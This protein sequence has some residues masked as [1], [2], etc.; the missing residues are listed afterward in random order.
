[1]KWISVAYTKRYCP[2]FATKNI[3][4][5]RRWV[6]DLTTFSRC[7]IENITEDYLVSINILRVST[8][9]EKV[10]RQKH[11]PCRRYHTLVPRL[12]SFNL[13]TSRTMLRLRRKMKI[14]LVWSVWSSQFFNAPYAATRKAWTIQAWRVIRTLTSAMPVLSSARY[15][16]RPTEYEN[17]KEHKYEFCSLEVWYFV[18]V[19]VLGLVLAQSVTL[20][21]NQPVSRSLPRFFFTCFQGE[22]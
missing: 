18:F 20:D 22:N 1:M 21:R 15:V 13:G 14:R 11:I 7:G 8:L 12:F 2:K 5:L 10:Y 16:G 9:L 6:K 3:R 4:W 17:E 19:L